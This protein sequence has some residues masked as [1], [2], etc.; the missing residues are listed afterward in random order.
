MTTGSSS[1]RGGRWT[2][3]RTGPSDGPRRRGGTT[4]PNRPATPS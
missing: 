4:S 2:S 3:S 1:S